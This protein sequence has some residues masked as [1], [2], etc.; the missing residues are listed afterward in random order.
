MG[1]PT[2]KVARQ[3]ILSELQRAGWA[4]RADLK[5]AVRNKPK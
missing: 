4:V 5:G 2:F 3:N 1:L